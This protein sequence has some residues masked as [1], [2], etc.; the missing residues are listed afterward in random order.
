[1]LQVLKV[2]ATEPNSKRVSPALAGHGVMFVVLFYFIF[3]LR[4]CRL[5]FLINLY[6]CVYKV[7][8]SDCK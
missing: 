7:M 2:Y 1:M 6:L 8:Y 5:V 3:I 4:K